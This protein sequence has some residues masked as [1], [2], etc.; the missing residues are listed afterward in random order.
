MYQVIQGNSLWGFE[1]RISG[2]IAHSKPPTTRLHSSGFVF[3]HNYK[4]K[5]EG[6]AFVQELGLFPVHPIQFLSRILTM[7]LLSL[8]PFIDCL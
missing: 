7:F 2:A 5:R 1:P 6:K 3:W 4:A 8:H